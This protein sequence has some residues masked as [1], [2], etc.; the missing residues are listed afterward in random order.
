VRISPYK[1]FLLSAAL[2][3]F[4]LFNVNAKAAVALILVSA[5]AYFYSPGH[6]PYILA[7]SIVTSIVVGVALAMRNNRKQQRSYQA[8]SYKGDVSYKVVRTEAPDKD[9]DTALKKTRNKK[10]INRIAVGSVAVTCVA[11]CAFLAIPK[12]RLAIQSS[13]SPVASNT[14]TE[15]T[16]N[17]SS[18]SALQR[19]A[20]QVIT[21]KNGATSFT[22]AASDY[23]KSNYGHY[24]PKIKLVCDQTRYEVSFITDE[25]L[26]TDS[27]GFGVKVDAK[28]SLEQQWNL[29]DTYRIA[30]PGNAKSFIDLL[31][32]GKTLSVSYQPFGAE[33]EKFAEFDLTENAAGVVGVR[34][35]CEPGFLP[36]PKLQAA[37]PEPVLSTTLP[38]PEFKAALPEPESRPALPEPELQPA[39]PGPELEPALIESEQQAVSPEPELQP[40]LPAPEPALIESVQQP[41]L[42]EPELKPALPGPETQITLTEPALKTE[43]SK[44]I[45]HLSIP[46]HF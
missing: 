16:T 8:S 43:I 32:S 11:V 41:A 10:L 44:P 26:G 34:N 9:Y 3:P 42:P 46:G 27:V 4:G 13:P 23:Q 19:V 20:M 38:E 6:W 40:A 36:E 5:G 29:D 31:S 37:K 1:Q 30:T 35:R 12:A 33:A 21:E 14:T 7:V 15:D 17:G 18:T 25:I 2:G 39:L 45:S 28:S 24:R 22:L